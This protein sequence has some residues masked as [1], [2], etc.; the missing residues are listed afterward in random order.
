MGF[1]RD[2]PIRIKLRWILAVSNVLVVI[3]LGSVMIRH[4]RTTF[5]GRTAWELGVINRIVASN[6]ASLLIFEDQEFA[7]KTLSDLGFLPMMRSAVVFRK[8]ASVFASW[9]DT[10]LTPEFLREQIDQDEPV[11]A[12]GC[13]LI[14]Q[15][16]TWDGERAGSLVLAYDMKEEIQRGRSMLYFFSG[17]SLTAML[18]S[19]LV[20]ERL[21]RLISRPISDLA[22]AAKAVSEK[23][24]YS[25]RVEGQGRDEVGQLVDA[26]NEMLDQV[27][28]REQALI[29]A[30][31]AKS[32][33]L[34][35]MSHE[36]R[37]PMNGVI[38]MT[39]LL[40]RTKL[41][42]D[43]QEL[44]SFIKTSADHLL[45]VINDILDFSKAE[46]GMMIIEKVPFELKKTLDEIQI[47]NGG[48]AAKKDLGFV[49]DI[50]PQISDTLVGD[51]VRIKQV[52]INL[53]G[54]AVKFT[55][56]GS[57][58]LQVKAVS[59]G[60]GNQKLK[61]SVIDTGIG[62]P[63]KKQDQIF[64][65]F[66]QADSSTTRSFG[67]TG[68]GLAISKQIVE[69]MHGQ[70]GVK[71]ELGSGSEFWFI[72]P[73]KVHT[74]SA[75]EATQQSKNNQQDL[76]PAPIANQCHILLAEDNKVNQFYAR[77]VLETMGMLVTVAD[78][79]EKAVELVQEDAFDL[80]LMDCQMPIVDGYD[81]TR[82]IRELGGAYETL[83][84]VALTA[85][86]MAEDRDVCLAAG[87]DDYVT[88]PV[89][90]ETLR[91]VMS[92]WI[93]LADPV[94]QA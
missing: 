78:N 69:L 4:D 38:G 36:L 60:M 16:V 45:S 53:I 49:M 30:S 26:F 10:T 66:T 51:P 25:V 71:S 90:G 12:S 19:M 44:V 72:L 70:I 39:D 28:E 13:M 32:D 65:Q 37:T 76:R 34:A 42:P 11:Y 87:M 63:R 89:D 84:I 31:R 17:L 68:L 33:F 40:E 58:T 18:I 2:L 7:E 27:E 83:P 22:D 5:E 48:Q 79:G 43:Q 73:M 46:A 61:F 20:S 6:C 8:N 85:F 9:G 52:L 75:V 81:A 86:A 3:L 77:K 1:S 67:G 64:D 59:S 57:V 29:Q 92:K 88:K 93:Q 82:Q 94:E 55:E 91:K 24:T 21:Q 47:I 41:P 54:N 50:D 14:S 80:V 15:P 23:Q 35:N 56:A 62:I 74:E